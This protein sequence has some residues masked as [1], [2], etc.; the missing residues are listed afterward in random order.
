MSESGQ[1]QQQQ[2]QQQQ[3]ETK[4]LEFHSRSKIQ[5]IFSD[6]DT[7]PHKC[8]YS[9]LGSLSKMELFCGSPKNRYH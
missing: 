7:I 4:D 5:N 8:H 2:Q 9:Y 3:S 6:E 1:Q